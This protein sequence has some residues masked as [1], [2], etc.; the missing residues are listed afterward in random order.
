M[1]LFLRTM[2]LPLLIIVKGYVAG[3]LFLLSFLILAL[4]MWW[5]KRKHQGFR[6][7]ACAVVLE[8][9]PTASKLLRDLSRPIDVT[10]LDATV[11]TF[12]GF[13]SGEEVCR[14]FYLFLLFVWSA[15]RAWI[16]DYET[17]IEMKIKKLQF[18]HV[19][20]KK[21]TWLFTTNT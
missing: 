13:T 5:L 15:M 21:K 6:D 12:Y 7:G 18:L 19:K 1:P 2:E 20:K 9:S 16:I 8:R 3:L 11:A 14:I 10:F 4:C 17:L